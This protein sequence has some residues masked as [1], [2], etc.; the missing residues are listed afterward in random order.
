M[1]AN[2]SG[3]KSLQ[4]KDS[5]PM[6]PNTPTRNSP[7]LNGFPYRHLEFE[8]QSIYDLGNYLDR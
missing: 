3:S 2:Q 5:S 4:T 8:S 1:L 7:F 6:C